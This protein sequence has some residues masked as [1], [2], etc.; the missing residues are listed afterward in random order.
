MSAECEKC[1]ND[2]YYTGDGEHV[3]PI[4]DRDEEIAKL[5]TRLARAEAVCEAVTV[6]AVSCN[7]YGPDTNRIIATW[8]RWKEES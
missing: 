2:L 7:Y 1:G 6:W 3:C 5:K 4:C 8:K